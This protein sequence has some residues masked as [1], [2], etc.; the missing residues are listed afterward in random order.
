MR[1]LWLSFF[2]IIL[3]LNLDAQNIKAKYHFSS[4]SELPKITFSKTSFSDSL[5]CLNYLHEKQALLQEKGFLELSID[6]V[7]FTEFDV[8]V[9]VYIGNQYKNLQIDFELKFE[10]LLRQSKSIYLN[11]SIYKT[12]LILEENSKIIEYLENHGYPYA[13]VKLDSI[14]YIKEGIS[15]FLDIERGERILYDSVIVTGNLKVSKSFLNGYTGIRPGF[16][17]NN[18]KVKSIRKAFNDLPVAQ[19]DADIELEK[20]EDKVNI[21]I[22]ADKLSNNRFDGILGILPNDETTGELVLTGEINISLQNMLKSVESINF[23]WE[24]LEST[25]QQLEIDF[26]IPYIFNTNIGLSSALN[27]DKHDSTF[28]NSTL[29]AGAQYYFQGQNNLGFQ[30]KSK[31][32]SVLSEDP[33]VKKQFSPYSLNSYGLT[34]EYRKLDYYFNPRKGLDLSLEVNIGNKDIK[35]EFEQVESQVQYDGQLKA[36]LFLPM[37]KK[38]T[39]LLANQTSFLLSETMFVNELYRIG[40]LSSIR[41]FMESSIYA[42]TYSIMSFEYRFVFER[43]SA[44]FTFFDAAWYEKKSEQYF[45]DYPFGFGF[46]LFFKTK[47]GIFTISYAMGQQK[48]ENLNI[49]NAKIH[50]GFINKF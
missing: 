41:G 16:E 24:K 48:N 50:F 35:T 34:F 39:V 31:T 20:H 26:K 47:A 5:A 12:N 38:H 44:L 2:L 43:N 7:R 37:G 40:G 21:K 30:F 25:S 28:L 8:N 17:Y 42:S 23:K 4:D 15:A 9:F 10:D 29:K 1:K 33:V 3:F 18:K 13:K 11:K 14:K 49:K 6:S 19:E 45:Y 46:G 32:S 36:K 22:P 27:I